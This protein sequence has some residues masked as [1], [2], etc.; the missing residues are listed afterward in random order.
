P[1]CP[2]NKKADQRFTPWSA[3]S[4]FGDPFGSPIPQRP[5]PLDIPPRVEK[6]ILSQMNH[7]NNTQSEES[8]LKPPCPNCSASLKQQQRERLVYWCATCRKWFDGELKKLYCHH[9]ALPHPR[10]QE[11]YQPSTLIPILGLLP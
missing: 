7:N 9:Y 4:I 5:Q 2:N 1:L 8:P 11:A 6:I 10:R 3:F